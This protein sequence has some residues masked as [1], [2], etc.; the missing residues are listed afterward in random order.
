MDRA[1]GA[2]YEVSRTAGETCKSVQLTA[3]K[4]KW[5]E[6]VDG[7]KQFYHEKTGRDGDADGKVVGLVAGGILAIKSASFV[8]GVIGTG[9]VIGT[10]A[11]VV[12]A[13]TN[14]KGTHEAIGQAYSGANSAVSGA[15]QLWQSAVEGFKEGNQKEDKKKR[16]R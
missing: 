2:V 13:V 10:G 5:G 15:Q 16:R 14:D 12:S 1:L 9:L 11:V 7:V 8:M 4:Q 3:E 6:K